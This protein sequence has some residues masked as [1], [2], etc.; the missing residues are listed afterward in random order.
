MMSTQRS[1]ITST[2]YAGD[3]GVNNA[4]KVCDESC[5][6]WIAWLTEAHERNLSAQIDRP[7][8]C[9]ARG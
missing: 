5:D 1:L 8:H 3:I 6:S 9:F 7:C 4:D 2:T